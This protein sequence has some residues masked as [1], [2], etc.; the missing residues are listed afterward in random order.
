MLAEERQFAP[1]ALPAND[2]P[3]GRRIDR[4]RL[5]LDGLKTISPS[6]AA[7]IALHKLAG[8]DVDDVI[9]DILTAC[10]RSLGKA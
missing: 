1:C 7:Q 2:N 8:R 5:L 10:R 6:F 3:P 9:D 4:W